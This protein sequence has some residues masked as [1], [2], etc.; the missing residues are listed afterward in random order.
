MVFVGDS[1]VRHAYEGL[2][3]VLSGNYEWGAMVE[4]GR[5]KPECHGEGQFEERTCRHFVAHNKQVCN[6]EVVLQLVYG[7][8]PTITIQMLDTYDLVLWGAG[9]HPV[10]GNYQTRYGVLNATVVRDHVLVPICSSL[11]SVIAIRRS[12]SVLWLG[13]HMRLAARHEDEAEKE[14][15]RYN[16][17]MNVFLANLCNIEFIDFYQMTKSLALFLAEEAVK[18]TWDSAHWGRAVNII[19]ARKII[20]FLEYGNL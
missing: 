20:S 8:W 16:R 19:K 2:L 11:S 14:I 17:E 5:E 9:S 7:A 18:M 12:K 4:E 3:L 6:N 1:F 15:V 13:I 10:D